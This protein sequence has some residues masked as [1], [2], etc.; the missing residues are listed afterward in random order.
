[1]TSQGESTWFE[2][3]LACVWA[4]GVGAFAYFLNDVRY[5]P[6]DSADSISVAF[7]LRPPECTLQLLWHNL[8]FYINSHFGILKTVDFLYLLGPVS[9]ALLAFLS[10]RLFSLLLPLSLRISANPRRWGR[11]IVYV[12]P[13]L[14][15]AIFVFSSPVW[16]LG[17]VFLSESMALILF[18]LAVFF[19]VRSFVRLSSAGFILTGVVSG[20]LSAETLIGFLIPFFAVVYLRF[21]RYEEDDASRFYLANPLLQSV[22]I[23]WMLFAFVVFWVIGLSF[24]M[25]FFSAHNSLGSGVGVFV[26]LVR[27]FKSYGVLICS[28]MAPLGCA[29]AC[30]AVVSPVVFSYARVKRA[31]DLKNFLFIRHGFFFM[32]FGV[33]ALLQSSPYSSW[34]F[35]RWITEIKL[36]SSDFLL[37]VCILGTAY[38]AF[39]AICVFVV[40]IYFRNTRI[41]A[42]EFFWDE[43]PDVPMI[44]KIKRALVTS[45]RF[46]RFVFMPLVAVLVVAVVI[47]GRINPTE[48]RA[49]AI[50]DEYVADVVRECPDAPV[51][52]TDGAVDALIELGAAIEG[53]EIKA[54]SIMSGLDGYEAMLRRRVDKEN[55]YRN[56]LTAGTAEALRAWM[57]DDSPMI[58]N[59]AV[60]VGFELWRVNNKN[61]PECGGFL[62][63]TGANDEFKTADGVK[64]AYSLANKI[65]SF[66]EECDISD[67]ESLELRSALSRV[68]WRLS[69]M[70]RIRAYIA[71]RKKDGALAETENGMADRLEEANPEYKKIKDA[72]DEILRK[73]ATLTL[74]PREGLDVSLRRAD[75]RLA[76][77]YAKKVIAQNEEDVS[78]NFALGMDYFG[79]H[80]YDKAEEYLLR[81]LKNAPKE[82]AIL[83]NLAVVLIRLDRFEEA[84][85]NA[86]KALEILPESKEVKETLRRIRE[87]KAEQDNK[88]KL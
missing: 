41:L 68:Q 26:R 38:A 70:C 21:H 80:R 55:K 31:T 53:K 57:R 74:T 81:A 86:L 4:L 83:N 52:I 25:S 66:R 61:I 44:V 34:W 35:W 82:P 1:M 15:S 5:I 23:K 6:V 56:E 72:G 71:G 51:L 43:N 87:L 10:T 12:L 22:L 36:I 19:A 18:V 7:G 20:V 77:I 17:E 24:N 46:Y 54:L 64:A 88:G 3:L 75:F 60:Q 84:E 27:A 32:V 62:A 45:G 13:V 47:I 73:N 50:V 67:V 37:G 29:F 39:T 33:L 65:L 42:R 63:K 76:G 8:V 2:R 14:G 69:R 85:T 40:D 79:N 59:L 78:A 58:S 30:L 9:L 48:V 16:A 11:M 49:K 28:M